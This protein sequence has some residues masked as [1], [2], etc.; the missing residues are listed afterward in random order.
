M[1]IG[2]LRHK[3]EIQAY[4]TTVD[5]DGYPIQDWVTVAHAWAAVEPV[6]GKE[7]WAA[8]AVQAE[9]TIKITMRPPGIEITP[10]NRLL[11]DG[12]TLEIQ[13]V[14]NVEERD[15]ELVLMCVEKA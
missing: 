2:T 10:A 9:T 6:A 15:R 7:Y 5:P 1:R 8:A 3:V 4:I 11:F 12:R 13:S 14:I